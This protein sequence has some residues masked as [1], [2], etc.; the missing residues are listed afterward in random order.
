MRGIYIEEGHSSAVVEGNDADFAKAIE[1]GALDAIGQIEVEGKVTALPKGL[2]RLHALRS[3]VLRA[4]KLQSLE[5]LEE[6]GELEELVVEGGI[7]ALP[8]GLLARLPNLRT[9]EVIAPK[10]T[11]IPD[12]IF[13]LSKLETL[14]L[15]DSKVTSLPSGGWG[16]LRALR[17]VELP[18]G[19]PFPDDLGDAP[20]E[21]SEWDLR[22]Q[23]DQV[24][25]ESF[26][27]LAG[28]AT[29]MLSNSVKKLPSSMAK[30]AVLE[31]LYLG[32]KI[33]AL[34]D[35]IGALPR[36]RELHVQDSKLS[37]LPD[38]LG[39]APSLVTLHIGDNQIKKIPAS[40]GS[41]PKLEL[42]RLS[43]NPISEIP[44]E[45]A[46][47]RSLKQ[48]GLS[49][50]QIVALPP[51]FANLALK[52]LTLPK[53]NEAAIR[54]SSAAVLDALGDSVVVFQ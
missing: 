9:L 7:T 48:L 12:E 17:S 43:N 29:L 20:L 35:D 49:G 25:P 32:N 42:L 13:T 45:L 47:L 38:S 4:K 14:R 15:S 30:M 18:H 19:A 41:A 24:L 6:L 50:T 40:L 26:G 5:G 31:V 16:E 27:R 53:A 54:A 51:A 52:A 21:M 33:T 44:E 8:P 36:L 46:G 10:I 34:P 22:C 39:H 1:S 3:L 2:G 11:T 23:R 28:I 37:K